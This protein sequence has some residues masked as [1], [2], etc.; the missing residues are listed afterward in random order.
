MAGDEKSG[1]KETPA[2]EASDRESERGDVAEPDAPTSGEENEGLSTV[3]S[4]DPLLGVQK[5]ADDE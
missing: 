5:D 1:T 4:A 3:L 2:G